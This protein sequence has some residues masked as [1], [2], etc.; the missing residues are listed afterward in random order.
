MLTIAT[1]T[2]SC[3]LSHWSVTMNYRTKK[4]AYYVGAYLFFFNRN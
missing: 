4:Y 3:L 1:R 2:G